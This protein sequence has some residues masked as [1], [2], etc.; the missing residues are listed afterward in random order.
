MAF[1]HVY[2]KP[3]DV[4]YCFMDEINT[5]GEWTVIKVTVYAEDILY[6]LRNDKLTFLTYNDSNFRKFFFHTKTEAVQAA[7]T[8]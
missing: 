3:G 7:E 8:K 5:I 2:A 6:Q 1:V 4:V